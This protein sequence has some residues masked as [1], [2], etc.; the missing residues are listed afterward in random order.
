[1]S[2]D[3]YDLTKALADEAALMEEITK[4]GGIGARIAA[5]TIENRNQKSSE[6]VA[7]AQ[8]LVS[9]ASKP[10]RTNIDKQTAASKLD[11]EQR[12]YASLVWDS[13]AEKSKLLKPDDSDQAAQ[14][15]E[16]SE[17]I[18][19]NGNPISDYQTLENRKLAE[20][21]LAYTP[22]PAFASATSTNDALGAANAMD[23]MRDVPVVSRG[24]SLRERQRVAETLG[25]Q[26]A[27]GRRPRPTVPPAASFRPPA[28]SQQQAQPAAKARTGQRF[29]SQLAERLGFGKVAEA[30]PKATR[31]SNGRP[32]LSSGQ[33]TP[34]KPTGDAP[35][36]GT[37]TRTRRGPP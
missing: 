35:I 13:V 25:R 10:G 31:L 1:M 9:E 28:T 5:K 19:S 4:A 12:R 36:S 26:V 11:L 27:P 29:M 6:E 2:D 14:A 23:A 37:S 18:W 7:K 32:P 20:E 21:N 8:R 30:K 17:R 15:K 33:T 34:Q 3:N 24:Q 22:R 16:N